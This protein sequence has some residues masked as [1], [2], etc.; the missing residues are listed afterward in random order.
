MGPI[1]SKESPYILDAKNL[2]LAR[3]TERDNRD[4][5]FPPQQRLPTPFYFAFRSIGSMRGSYNQS[6]IFQWVMSMPV[7][8]EQFVKQLADSGV[9]APGKL[10]NFIPPKAFPKD[11]QELARQLVQS[12]HLTK[13]QA[14]EIYG[15]RSKSLILGNYTIL[16]KIGA[17]GMGQVFKAEHRRMHRL[18]A[19]KML[20]AATM[21]DA[22]A[23][24][25]FQREVEAAAKLRHPNIVATDDADEANGVHFLVMEYVEGSDLSALVKKNGPLPVARAVNYV[26]QAARGLE[27]AHGEGVVHRDI[28][29]ANLLLDKKGTV[30]ILDMG[31]A[32]IDTGGDTAT[33]AELTGTGA[34]LG[35]VDYMAPE[36]ALSTKHVDARA[37]IYSLGCSLYYLVTAHAA[38]DG[39][40]LM[41]KL[42]AHREQP[43]PSLGDEV[44]EEVQAVFEKMVAKKVQ[45]RY[46]TMSE[47]VA[48]LEQS[49]S[50]QQTSVSFQQS[51]DT[52]LDSDALTFLRDAPP[53]T[54]HVQKKT[55]KAAPSKIAKKVAPSKSG[56]DNKKLILGAV[57]AGFL[58][59]AILA[60][61]IFKLR[62]KDG[63]LVVEVNQPDAVVR[64]LDADGKVEISQK[65]GK[66]PISISVDPGKHRLK[67]EKDGF[68]FFAKD[69]EMESGGTASIKANLVDDKPWFKPAFLEWQRE[70]AA[71]P[72]EQQ[73]QAVA[74]KLQELN[75]GFDGL[76][77][78][79]F[80]DQ[81]QIVKGEVMTF[82]FF[83]TDTVTDISP[84]RALAGLKHLNC[85][86]LSKLSDLSPLTGMLLTKLSFFA[87]Q[88]S[89][90]TAIQ[91][92]PLEEF[93]CDNT[94]VSN[95]SPLKGMKL[96]LLYCLGTR[97]TDLSPLKGMDLTTLEF[98]PKN[99]TQGIDVIR[100]MKSLTAIGPQEKSDLRAD[101]FWKKYD[102]GEFGKPGSAASTPDHKPIA[103]VNDPAFQQWMKT[104]AALPPEK[105]VEAV[106]KKLQEL[107]PGFDGKE[108]HK[109]E[110][111]VVTEL[112]FIT[113][114]VTDISPV[115]ALAGLK[116]LD[117]SSTSSARRG[118]LSDLSPL[119]GL[120]LTRLDCGFT[121]VADLSP[122][123]DMP[124]VNLYLRANT[125]M[126]DLSPLKGMPL[127]TLDCEY[128]AVADLSP[129][130]GKALTDLR[131]GATQVSDLSSL[132]GMPLTK[133]S[134][135]SM[136]V[137]DLS[138]LLGMPLTYLDCGITNVS[139]LSPLKGMNLTWLSCG[140]TQV[141]DLSPIKGMP[142]TLLWC[143][144]TKI[145][146]LS[147]LQGMNLTA[148]S[149]TPRNITTGLYIIRQMKSLK[150]IG[151]KGNKP[152]PPDEFWKKY[153]AGDFGKPDSTAATS[154]Q[155]PIT[156]INDPV[157]QR[158]MKTVAALPAEK[159]VEAVVK[160][161]QELN[162]GF[163]GQQ[164]HQIEAG[165]LT[166]LKLLS[167]SI[168]DIS[169]VKALSNLRS[170]SCEGLLNKASPL[171]DLSP[172]SGMPVKKLSIDR[173][174]VKSLEPL[175]GMKLED[176]A[177][178]WTKVNDLS[179][180]AGMP[181]KSMSLAL[182]PVED[183]SPLTGMPLKSIW[184][185]S[186]HVRNLQP[187]AG[188]QITSIGLDSTEVS[189]L[190]PLAG[191]PLETIWFTPQRITA[192]IAEI[193]RT[194][195]QRLAA[196]QKINDLPAAEFW[197]K[198]DAGEFGKPATA[199]SGPARKPVT[200]INNP[201]FQQWMK[202]VAALPGEQQ[203]EAVAK[204]LQE[205][206]PGFDGKETHE[207]HDRAVTALRF[208][209]DAIT[210]ISPVRALRDLTWLDCFGSWGQA[211]RFDNLA[212][213]AGMKLTGLACRDTKVADLSPLAGMQLQSLDLG[214][215]RVADLVPL[216][217]MPL[218][219]FLCY[220][221]P[222]VDL[223]PLH[224]APLKRLNCGSTAVADLSPLRGMP[225]KI[226]EC[227]ASR[228]SDLAPL[229]GMALVQL[230]CHETPVADLSPLRGMKLDLILFTPKN[231]TQGIDAIR[232]MKGLKTIGTGLE[233]KNQFS[234]D[235]FWKKYDMGEFN[236]LAVP[237]KLR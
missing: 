134:C 93:L 175:R 206:N 88:V 27:F 61:V 153:D 43:I 191:M 6:S 66:G 12:K 162:P 173:T 117:C 2:E 160:K 179:P 40:S 114:N 141:S 163:D 133:L 113:D 180:L 123:R 155:K 151:I 90:I 35:T 96:S 22:V 152:F 188:M 219:N 81:P 32:R 164:T 185:P 158:W 102:A 217:G 83:N 167:N 125:P 28:K 70:V 67:V 143:D 44:P 233:V 53:H 11:T 189:D 50:G 62:T 115:R 51:V 23:V 234:P 200:D 209:T 210:D 63:T 215:T 60:A 18:V 21:T 109:I 157:F 58:G 129:L 235:E 10:E 98:T 111:G 121:Q 41:A 31:L 221:T 95:L 69:F 80:T 14:Q 184:L 112:Q 149:V 9:I 130:K 237:V 120:T 142:L 138:P 171:V 33:Q 65:G 228:V 227:H 128:T 154:D 76:V 78:G 207:I 147:P 1:G 140:V 56:K 145:S 45:D 226:L 169:P 211:A 203:V 97:L 213:L 8:L 139:D 103:N 199:A 224:G 77:A 3:G 222:V 166:E 47:V 159:Q 170:F 49:S 137:S 16:D 225:L 26:L 136:A 5:P 116:Q 101:E 178:S 220:G 42:L 126:S 172:L 89:D 57:G 223:T 230:Q 59:V 94:P 148:V 119:R 110:N 4:D 201:A 99:I 92:M 232:H 176:L 25:R 79:W 229:R 168:T 20:P 48:A 197:K 216:K 196:A 150:T 208:S 71:L 87:T 24:A 182:D 52:N 13:F 190:S 29:P 82:G 15:G 198:Y 73:V 204:K 124:L 55:K 17:G 131:I 177:L 108:T 107:D 74:R 135:N 218:E 205:F 187:L 236:K 127:T 186:T 165:V 192:G 86:R 194:Q 212:P 38:Y 85:G 132:R 181:L 231:I 19:I 91:G 183:L 68:K 84:L 118:T 54:S 30:K 100:Q 64:V 195:S 34:V 36:Q 146:D 161:L 174:S 144:T 104:V 46:Q 202:T 122:L 72:A 156:Q 7:A 193:R 105:Q 75:P 39:D 106:A 37:D 214:D